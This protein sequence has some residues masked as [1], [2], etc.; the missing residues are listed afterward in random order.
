ML[1]HSGCILSALLQDKAIKRYLVRNIVEQAAVRDVQDACV[2]D[3]YVLPKLYAKMQVR[4]KLR[5]YFI[6]NVE[7]KSRQVGQ[8]E[9][10]HSEHGTSEI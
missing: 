1:F 6:Q 8:V 4:D 3:G 9:R 5:V 2:F 7:R 10:R